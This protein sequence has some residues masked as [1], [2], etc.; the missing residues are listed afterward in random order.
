M[1]RTGKWIALR[2]ARTLGVTSLL[3]RS[4]WRRK[5]LGIL[6]YHGASL[7]DEH[8]WNPGL[9][10]AAATLRRRMQLIR[11]SG[12][13]VLPLDE[14]VRRL[15]EGRLPPRSL[16]LT[17]DDGA[18]DFYSV[19]YP[20][21]REFGFPVTVYLTTYY[22]EF[23]RPV[24]D[25]MCSYLLWKARGR[26]A[27]WPEVFGSEEPVELAGPGLQSAHERLRRYPAEQR[28][29]GAQKDALLRQL[30]EALDIDYESILRRRMLQIM[31][32]DEA[33]ELARR[34]VDFQLHTHRH[35]VS[36]NKALFQREIVENR[37]RVEEIRGSEAAH[38]C[39]PGGVNRPEFA[40][41]LREWSIRS[42][43]TCEFGIASRQSDAMRLP[44]FLDTNTSTED[45]FRSWL[46]G[47]RTFL[48][49]RIAAENRGQFM[50]DYMGGPIESTSAEGAKGS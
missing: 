34:G 29:T 21:L 19:A 27:R 43:T 15:Y 18:F 37:R 41:W 39:Y 40:A 22:S 4:S 16:A 5:R 31:S 6:C 35:R 49:R 23:N 25:P 46:S 50:E 12:C 13:T 2:A 7:D 9:Y 30:A 24:Y 32:Q 11:E 26:T 20:I 10:M 17:F 48:P 44:R 33:R 1:L 3:M 14:A 28:L 45:E 8:L 38:F 36:L 47:A 42:A